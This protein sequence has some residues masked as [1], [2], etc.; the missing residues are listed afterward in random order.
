MRREPTFVVFPLKGET[1][2]GRPART[3]VFTK[4]K[5]DARSVAIVVFRYVVL[6]IH[7]IGGAVCA[8]SC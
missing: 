7:F 4:L 6:T 8:A 5:A 1:C 2:V 3:E